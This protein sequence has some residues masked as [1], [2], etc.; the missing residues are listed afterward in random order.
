MLMTMN[1]NEKGRTRLLA[2]I[3]IIAM[4]VCVFAVMSSENLSAAEGDD[5]TASQLP[6][7][8]D[9]VITL[10]Q[11]FYDSHQMGSGSGLRIVS[12]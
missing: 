12:Y 1:M 4:V 2:A 10:T 5:S 9:G 7:P 11:E 3:A 8:V 6:E